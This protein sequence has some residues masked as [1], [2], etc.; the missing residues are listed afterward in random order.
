MLDGDDKDLFPGEKEIRESIFLAIKRGNS[1][2]L[3]EEIEKLSEILDSY[4]EE[5]QLDITDVLNHRLGDNC[6]T[7]LHQSASMNK[8]APFVWY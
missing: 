7:L 2:L 3:D 8:R 4:R 6:E 5:Y 1:D